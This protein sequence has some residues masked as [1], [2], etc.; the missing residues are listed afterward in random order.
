VLTAAQVASD[1]KD[2]TKLVTDFL[3]K[4]PDAREVRVAY[5]RSLVEQKDSSRRA[6]S[7]RRC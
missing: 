3:R 6:A 5:A 2:A 1:N 4:Y 7:S